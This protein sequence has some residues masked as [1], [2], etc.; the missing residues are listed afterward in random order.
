MKRQAE[1]VEVLDHLESFLGVSGP[2]EVGQVV[3]WGHCLVHCCLLNPG[4]TF[5]KVSSSFYSTF[6]ISATA[7]AAWVFGSF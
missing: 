5:L 7:L 1:R 2:G 4:Q 3:G 6:V